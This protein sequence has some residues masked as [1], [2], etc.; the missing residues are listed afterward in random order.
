[1]QIQ[2]AR[3]VHTGMQT[4]ST[5]YMGQRWPW[6]ALQSQGGTDMSPIPRS[7]LQDTGG[8]KRRM[9]VRRQNVTR[10]SKNLP[11]DPS[12]PPRLC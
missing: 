9:G 11:E 4:V 12:W 10:T 2:G 5:R 6:D 3:D 1:M 8:R 7:S